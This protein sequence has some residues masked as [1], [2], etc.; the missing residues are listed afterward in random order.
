MVA[1]ELKVA[2]LGIYGHSAV[3]AHVL[4]G[5]RGDVEER[6]LATVGIAHQSH[7][8][9]APLAQCHAL[10]L[11]IREVDHLSQSFQSLGGSRLEQCL[12]LAHHLN[13]L[14]LLAPQRD[15]IAHHAVF[16]RVLQRRIEHH[17]HALT[18]YKTHLYNSFSEASVS[19]HLDD[20]TLLPCIQL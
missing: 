16:N 20:D 14:S 10:H 11:F 2:L 4:V 7:V 8:D 15:F 12:V 9:G 3:V 19:H 5:S 17:L 13:H 1:L 6:G 18:L